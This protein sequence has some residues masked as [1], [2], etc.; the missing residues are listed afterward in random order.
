VIRNRLGRF[1]TVLTA[2]SMALLL[3]GVGA[4]TAKNPTWT[5]GFE[6]LPPSVSAGNDAG[7]L[8]T[9]KNQGPS[10]IND[11]N[12]TLTSEVAGQ[13]PSY[14]T[15][16]AEWALSSGGT[17]T[18]STATGAMVCN[19][20]TMADNDTATFTVAFHVPAGTTGSFDLYVNLRAGTGDTGADGG[21]SRGDTKTFTSSTGISTNP[22]FDGGFVA[23]GGQATYET[24]GSLGR[25]NKQT[26]KVE[27]GDELI[28]VTVED[29]L[30]DYACTD[31][32]NQIGTWSVLN[33]A[34]GATG[35]PIK[36][37][38]FIWGG[39]VPGGVQAGD[40]YLLHADGTGAWLP[41]TDTCN[42]A[43]PPSNLDCL[44]SVTKIGRNYKIVAWLEH[45]GGMRGA[46]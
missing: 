13:L 3:L 38:I 10:T 23:P 27:V 16:E 18:C 5:V 19:V 41:V 17:V 35:E 21:Q 26:T 40:I 2:A 42:A 36:V 32:P 45:N 44:E 14:L 9:V 24:T 29:E 28:P 43:T 20:G 46:Y 33:V 6:K 25:S 37:T 12:I 4:A 7:W 11:L 34:G 15:P 39:S 31:C 22:N 8:V 1:A 30:R